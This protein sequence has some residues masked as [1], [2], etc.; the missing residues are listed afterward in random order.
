[1]EILLK[2]LVNT[3]SLTIGLGVISRRHGLFNTKEGT[4]AAEE[5]RSELGTAI[6]NQLQRETKTMPD[7][8]TV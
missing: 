1:M 3:L 7:V 6:G 4:E 2:R 5:G 8:V